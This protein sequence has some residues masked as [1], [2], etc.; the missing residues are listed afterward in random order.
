MSFQEVFVGEEC[1]KLPTPFIRGLNWINDFKLLND[2]DE[3]EYVYG[4]KDEDDEKKDDTGAYFMIR[5]IGYLFHDMGDFSCNKDKDFFEFWPL[6]E[7][8][9]KKRIEVI[10]K[11]LDV[12]DIIFPFNYNKPILSSN[13]LKGVY[14]LM[15]RLFYDTSYPVMDE[16]GVDLNME[17]GCYGWLD[18]RKVLLRFFSKIRLNRKFEEFEEEVEGTGHIRPIRRKDGSSLKGSGVFL[19]GLSEDKDEEDKDEEDKDEEEIKVDKIDKN[20]PFGVNLKEIIKNSKIGF[21]LDLK[22]K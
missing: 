19:V 22:D 12:Y 5:N 8:E 6:R 1:V 17:L 15:D 13:S 2:I 20:F 4:N 11:C 16:I 9:I 7:T 21:K 18:L 10:N 14:K 3:C